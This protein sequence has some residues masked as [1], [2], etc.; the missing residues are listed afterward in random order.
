MSKAI[1]SKLKSD[2]CEKGSCWVKQKL[3]DAG[4]VADLR[5]PWVILKLDEHFASCVA[6]ADRIGEL[7]DGVG[8]LP[9]DSNVALRIFEVKPSLEDLPKAKAQLKKG[10]ELLSERLQ[11]GFSGMKV[12]LEIHVGRAPKNTMKAQ[13]LVSVNGRRFG[14]V[15]F[16]DGTK[17]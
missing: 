4:I 12:S 11:D 10:A 5:G 1:E 13:Q 9:Q 2:I 14:I 15:A 16:K 6:E 7:C 8:V 3:I 17:I